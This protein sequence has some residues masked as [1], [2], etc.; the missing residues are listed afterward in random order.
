MTD[1]FNILVKRAR[2]GDRHAF[3]LLYQEIYADLYRY[4]CFV[5]RNSQDAEDAVSEAVADAYATIGR[6]RGE[7]AFKSWMFTILSRKCKKQL[8]SYYRD[9]GLLNSP[10]PADSFLPPAARAELKEA[11]RVLSDEERMIVALTVFGG[12]T[13]EET[14]KICKLNRNT[15]RSKYARALKKLK[16]AL[17]EK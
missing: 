11:L 12:Y 13:S 9:G 10:P 15:V 4:A 1:S 17:E 5:L 3:S 8:R 2:K 16:A 14:A 7:D 6:L